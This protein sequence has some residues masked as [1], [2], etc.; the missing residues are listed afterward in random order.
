MPDRE[1]LSTLLEK[2]RAAQYACY[3]LVDSLPEE[4]DPESAEY[5]NFNRAQE[6]SLL[7]GNIVNDIST[8]LALQT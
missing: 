2:A 7:I 6:A 5:S 4:H 8:S 3:A 1:Q